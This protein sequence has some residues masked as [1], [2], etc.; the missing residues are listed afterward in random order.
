MECTRLCLKWVLLE[1][2]DP[3]SYNKFMGKWIHR[4]TNIDVDNRTATC[5]NCGPVGI[6]SNGIPSYK[7]EL[8]YY[9]RRVNSADPKIASK[10]KNFLQFVDI[11]KPKDC[12]ICHS[13]EP[14]HRDHDHKTGLPRGWLCRSCNLALGY[15]R[16]NISLLDTAK[17]YL[18]KE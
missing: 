18:S 6:I 4:L 8:G 16:D 11:P 13:T 7:C 1:K 12:D 3:F 9:Q 14:L 5:S 2:E 10:A 15:F 17:E